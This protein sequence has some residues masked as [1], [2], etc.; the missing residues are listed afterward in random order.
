MSAEELCV[1]FELGAF[2]CALPT[3]FVAR[4]ET[5]YEAELRQS[6]VPAG[7]PLALLGTVVVGG[8]G[9][10]AWD[11]GALLQAPSAHDAWVALRVEGPVGPVR[12]ALRT[13]RCIGVM[14]VRPQM[15]LVS[16]LF[17]ARGRAF[18]GAF[19]LAA[20]REAERRVGVLLDPTH[21]L[22]PAELELSAQVA[23]A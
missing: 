11:L 19:E 13:G 8:E 22:E 14:P 16:V 18:R 20:A 4:L 7:A 5:S 6:A 9:F 17:R 1:V 21:L 12:I 15:A 23:Q 3:R 2:T 10:G